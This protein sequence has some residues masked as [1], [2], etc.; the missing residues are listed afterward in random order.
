[1]F[2]KKQTQI[3]QSGGMLEQSSPPA[4]ILVTQKMRRSSKWKSVFPM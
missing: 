4:L 3:E 1:M 2:V